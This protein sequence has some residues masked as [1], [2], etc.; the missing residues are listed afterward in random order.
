MNS[1]AKTLFKTHANKVL[2][3]SSRGKKE[4]IWNKDWMPGPYPVTPAEREAAA[5]K[6]NLLPEEYEPDPE[7]FGDYPN[8]PLISGASKDPWRNW[9]MPEHKKDYG[10]PMHAMANMITEDRWDC[11]QVENTKVHPAKAT[12]MYVGILLAFIIP[13]YWFED[14]KGSLPHMKKHLPADGVHYKYPSH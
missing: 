7:G 13:C 12:L 9:N 11:N 1:L 14:K 5:Q 6:Y 3:L 8:L 2:V 4:L 10:E